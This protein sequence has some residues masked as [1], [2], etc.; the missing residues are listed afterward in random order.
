[1]N[2]LSPFLVVHSDWSTEPWTELLR[3]HDAHVQQ[4]RISEKREDFWKEW[5]KKKI[6]FIL[7]KNTRIESEL[8]HELISLQNMIFLKGVPSTASFQPPVALFA[9]Q[10]TNRSHVTLWTVNRRTANTSRDRLNKNQSAQAQYKIK[11]SQISRRLFFVES[12]FNRFGKNCKQTNRDVTCGSG[13][14]KASSCSIQQ[15]LA[16]LASRA[17]LH[18]ALSLRRIHTPRLVGCNGK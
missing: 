15:K 12:Q 18:Q 17:W 6:K 14:W 2:I 7:K 16:K 8:R 11:A 9:R 13:R 10:S 3:P 5:N 1:M 4:G